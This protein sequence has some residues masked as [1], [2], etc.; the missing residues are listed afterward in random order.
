[1]PDRSCGLIAIKQMHAWVYPPRG[2]HHAGSAEAPRRISTSIH[3][4]RRPAVGLDLATVAC[5]SRNERLRHLGGDVGAE[6]LGKLG[7]EIGSSLMLKLAQRCKLA[8][9]HLCSW[10]HARHPFGPSS[11]ENQIPAGLRRSMV[12]RTLRTPLSGVRDQWINSC[13]NI[14]PPGHLRKRRDDR[15]Q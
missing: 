1:M 5:D 2:G 4:A 14:L 12:W 6:R 7:L 13:V 11:T 3:Y 15:P 10:H 8:R 9:V